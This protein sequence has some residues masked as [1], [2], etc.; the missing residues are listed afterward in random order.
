M[1]VS[2]RSLQQSDAAIAAD[3]GGRDGL[4]GGFADGRA[5][6]M[7]WHAQPVGAMCFSADGAYLYSAGR[8]GVL[9][10]WQLHATARAFLPPTRRPVP[11]GSSLQQEP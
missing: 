3:K 10:A 4:A 11:P 8:E 9:V 5:R 2:L 1:Q 7:H 6:E